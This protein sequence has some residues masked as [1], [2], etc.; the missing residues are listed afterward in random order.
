MGGWTISKTQL[1]L[2][3]VLSLGAI[4]HALFASFPAKI[5]FKDRPELGL[6]WE[7]LFPTAILD[8]PVARSTV[9]VFYDGSIDVSFK[10]RNPITISEP[11]EPGLGNAAELSAQ[12]RPSL[13]LLVQFSI[14][15]SE[16][17]FRTVLLQLLQSLAGPDRPSCLV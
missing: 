17:T 13:L 10:V 12:R 6:G 4:Y 3:I 14:T 15:R 2:A 8:G 16:I 11:L 1:R 5:S 7:L 9:S